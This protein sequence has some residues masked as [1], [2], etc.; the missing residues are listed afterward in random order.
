MFLV[1]IYVLHWETPKLQNKIHK[2]TTEQQP[3][4]VIHKVM[5][6]DF[7]V[8]EKEEKINLRSYIFSTT[9]KL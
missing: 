5:R 4:R 7:L 1:I 3:F 9:E 8:D 6:L 2:I